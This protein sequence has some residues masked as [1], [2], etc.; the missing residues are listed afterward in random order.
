MADRY[1]PFSRFAISTLKIF[2]IGVREPRVSFPKQNAK[3]IT[4]VCMWR[5]K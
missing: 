3:V 2:K 5:S 1:L 4:A